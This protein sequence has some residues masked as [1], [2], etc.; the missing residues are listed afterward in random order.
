MEINDFTHLHTHSEKSLLD[1]ENKISNLVNKAVELDF[2]NL[3]LTDHGTMMGSL[4]FYKACKQAGINGILGVELYVTNSPDNIPKEERV[5]DNFHLVVVA[6]NYTGYLNLMKL[7]SDAQLN[8]FYFKPR[9]SK[10]NLNPTTTEGLI[11]SSACLGSNVQRAGVFDPVTRTYSNI[12]A[13]EEVALWY[14]KA[15]PGNYYLEIQDN[16]DEA[17][18]QAA[19]NEVLKS[20]G[21]KYNIPLVITADAHYTTAKDSELHGMLMA[22]Q[23]KKTYKEYSAA[24]E[25]K[26]G[27]WFYLRSPQEMLDAARKYDC[28]E[29]FWNTCKIGKE[30]KIEI[31]LGKFKMP[32]FNFASESDYQEFLEY[33]DAEY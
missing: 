1:G 17:G 23:L 29:A 15:F 6:K 21:K 3:A 7:V 13:M 12:E 28:E 2:K 33:K 14:S 24:G 26:Y 27:P 9:V 19:Y 20:I 8:N 18:Q 32:T 25:M 5:R 11:A 30:C 22:M 4:E 16:P 31:E 10:D